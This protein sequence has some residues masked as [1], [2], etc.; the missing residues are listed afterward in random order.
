MAKRSQHRTETIA[1]PNMF[2]WSPFATYIVWASVGVPYTKHPDETW[3]RKFVPSGT[4]NMQIIKK[5]T[6]IKVEDGN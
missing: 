5:K 2:G 6:K 4:G 1:N 3:L